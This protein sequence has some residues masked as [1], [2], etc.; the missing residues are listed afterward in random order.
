MS[1][2]KLLLAGTAIVAVSAFSVTAN[3]AA[4]TSGA[5]GT[6]SG[7]GVGAG[8]SSTIAEAAAGDTVNLDAGATLTITNDGTNHD[9][10][11]VDGAVLG[12][13][14]NTAG[15]GNITTAQGTNT[16]T[17][18]IT[19][20]SANVG[21]NVGF[22]NTDGT[23]RQQTV[24]VTGALTVGGAFDVTN[25]NATTA[26]MGIAATVGGAVSVTGASTLTAGSAAGG[27]AVS[28]LVITGN[29][30]FTGGMTVTGGGGVATNDATL[31]LNG[32]TNTGAIT[33]TD[34][35]GQAILVLNGAADQS[36]AGV[37]AGDGD[38]TVTAG[39]TKNVAFAA[40]VTSG[41][42]A[43]G[44]TGE[45][46]FDGA[47]ASAVTFTAAGT[48]DLDATLTGA[49]DFVALDGTVAVADGANV[50]AV[51]STGAVGTL[52]LEGTTTV[53]G[54][55]GNTNAIKAVNVN[56]VAG[57]TA[58]F[59]AAVDAVTVTTGA[60]ASKFDGALTVTDLKIAG[61]G[62][63]DLNALGTGAL[64]FDADGT[65]DIGANWVG[66][67]DASTASY[68]TVNFSAAAAGVTTVG[69]TNK[70]KAISLTGAATT[71]ATTDFVAPDALNLGDD[72]LLDVTGTFD[73]VSGDN[74]STVITDSAGTDH[75]R[76]A[77]SGVAT[78]ATGTILTLSLAS[79]AA[80]ANAEE[81]TLL[82]AGTY[83]GGT[84][85]I[86]AL[87][88]GFTWTDTSDGTDLKVTAATAAITSNTDLTFVEIQS[89]DGT[90]IF[91]ALNNS[92][93]A[94]TTYD[95]KAE[96]VEATMPTVDGGAQASAIDVVHSV[97]GVTDTRIASLRSGSGM[98]AGSMTSS[99]SLWGQG[100]YNYAD[101]D[102]HDNQDG[103]SSDTGGIVIGMDRD[104]II[105]GAV[106]GL[107]VNY[108]VTKAESDNA[109]KTDT[110][111]DNYGVTVYGSYG[112]ENNMFVNAQLGYAN[113]NIDS[114]RSDCGG[115]GLVCNGDTDSKQLSAKLLVGKD[116]ANN[117]MMFTP[118]VYASYV[119]VDT[120]GYTE[121]GTGATLVVND[122]DVAALNLGVDL[123]TSWELKA[124]EGIMRPSINVGYAYDAIND[125]VEITSTFVAGATS[126]RKTTGAKAGNSA[127]NL[128]LGMVYETNAN[129]DLSAKYDASIKED[130][131]A[132]NG[133]IRLTTH[134]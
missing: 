42:I 39:G 116:Y 36:V 86:K 83:T 75:G 23:A 54:I 64:D 119:K 65:V 34:G 87:T 68:G 3:A 111:I 55:V 45:V 69:A 53:S 120:D 14:T 19:I 17:L 35:T 100:Y 85:T 93:D 10:T 107:A 79:D 1:I 37:I 60:G 48:V 44:T 115:A 24:D 52:T 76:A 62:A 77:V 9:G 104:D 6:W 71:I 109:N 12:A 61:A 78:V 56:G 32:A 121:T 7:A 49:L 38:I 122:N 89:N 134:F 110:D 96:L 103:Y 47:V 21:G 113:N 98:A 58:T 80:I 73:T 16:T 33:L 132:H 51:D 40:A 22:I 25:S 66:A 31:T 43:I 131:Q 92:I 95:A 112:L 74:I 125:A 30:A 90:G 63:I 128:G 105:D 72:N 18:A 81:I 129:W 91:T 11:G 59:D 26:A 27:T 133:T 88:P 99:S 4:I 41:T 117:K 20:D 118:K 70:L 84:L 2:K 114:K 13:V 94:A 127:L 15:T 130:Y 46:E 8:D 82:A 108:G 101:Q 67:M 123:E 97:Q 106:I 28:T 29:S 102:E 57:K 124:R 50:D 126:A 5:T